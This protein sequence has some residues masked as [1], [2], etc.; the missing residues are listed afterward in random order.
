MRLFNKLLG[1][2]SASTPIEA[3]LDAIDEARI[4]PPH[5]TSRESLVALVESFPFW[6]QHIYLGQGVY[7]LSTP[8]LHNRLWRFLEPMLPDDLAGASVLDVGTNAGYFCIKTKLKGAGKVIGVDNTDVFLQQAEACRAVWELDI[9]YRKLDADHLHALDQRFDIVI[10]TGILYHLK[11]P[12]GVLEQVAE[13]CNDAIVVETEVIPPTREN[14]V[15][16]RLGPR[17]RVAVTACRQGFMKF[18]EKDELNEDGSNWWVPDTECVLGML[19]TA[20]FTHFS[21]PRYLEETRMMLV[22]TKRPQSLLRL[23]PSS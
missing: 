7:T 6:Y 8:R 22:A 11:N 17:G 5:T 12:L 16:V 18:I 19:R 21:Q 10:F 13:M 15:H 23:T 20:G 3:A 1:E 2:R 14:I 4:E 9:D